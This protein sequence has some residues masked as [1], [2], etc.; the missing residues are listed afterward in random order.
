MPD[1]LNRLPEFL[2]TAAQNEFLHTAAI[3]SL[4][5]LVH[6]NQVRKEIRVQFSEL[7]GVLKQD[8]EAQKTV[9]AGV[10]TRVDRLE[11]EMVNSL[12]NAVKQK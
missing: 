11:Q 5:A 1:F 10:A 3:F 12:I 7:V 6:A 2:G 9:L 8:L 4:A